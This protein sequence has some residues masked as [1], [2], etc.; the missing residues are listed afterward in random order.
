MAY[1]LFQNYKVVTTALKTSKHRDK[2]YRAEIHRA[3]IYRAVIY[4]AEIHPAQ[5]YRAG[6]ELQSCRANI[7]LANF[8]AESS[9]CA[10]V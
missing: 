5:I 10:R 1:R 7:H 6:T 3:E 4:R 8:C 2:N 9:M